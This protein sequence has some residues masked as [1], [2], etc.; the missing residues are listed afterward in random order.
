LC[1]GAGHF[2]EVEIP[3]K[4]GASKPIK[5]DKNGDSVNGLVK[6]WLTQ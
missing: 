6:I 5:Y 4:D 1:S 3:A 2:I